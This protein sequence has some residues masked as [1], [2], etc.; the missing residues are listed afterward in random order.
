[1]Q[2]E[3]STLLAIGGLILG[4][5]TGIITLLVRWLLKSHES[6][7]KEKFDAVDEKV[8]LIKEKIASEASR[9]EAIH[10]AYKEHVDDRIETLSDRDDKFGEKW[11]NFL[12]KYY[13]VDTTRSNRLDAAFNLIDEMKYIMDDIKPLVIRKIDEIAGKIQEDLKSEIGSKIGG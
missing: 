3:T 13:R 12:E 2:V 7:L 5:Y 10:D 4:V 9:L 6:R 11:E 1:M 8:D